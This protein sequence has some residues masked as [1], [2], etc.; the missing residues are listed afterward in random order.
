MTIATIML[1]MALLMILLDVLAGFHNAY[2]G[3]VT[4][5]ALPGC[6]FFGLFVAVIGIVRTRRR[7]LKEGVPDKLPVIDL[8]IPKQRVTATAVALGGLVLMALSGFGSYKGYEYTE[9]VQFC[10]T[11]CHAVMEPE[12]TTYQGSPHARVAC[13]GCHIGDGVDW[14]VKSKLSGSYQ[15]YATLLNKYERPIKTPVANLRPAKETCEQCHWPKHFFTQKLRTHEYFL[16]DEENTQHNLGMLVK[17][18]GGEGAEAQGIHA[19]MYLDT[20]V[21]YI[22]TDYERQEIPYVEMK[23]KDGK[24]I[25]YRDPSVK[26][27]DAD[28]AKSKRFVVDCIDCHNRPTHVFRAPSKTIDSA[29]ALG[30][31]DKTIPEI[32]SEAV[33]M[34]DASYKTKD[35]AIAKIGTDL[36]SYYNENYADFMKKDRPKLDS[37]ISVIQGIYRQNYFPEMKTDWRSHRDNLD[38]MRGKGCFRCHNNKLVSSTGKKITNDCKT[39]H[40]IVSQ[41][42]PGKEKTNYQG[43][44]FQHPV[45]I[46]N[47]WK[48]TPCMECHGA[49]K[50]E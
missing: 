8:N 43:M 29:L 14:Y 18:G 9:S 33:E 1:V 28:I 21:S 7:H 30:K 36:V 34:L 4:Y 37:A 20:E 26:L 12:Y 40:L 11:T 49:K 35:E 2:A 6:M 23:D 32:K 48:T 13:V 38:H 42:A 16:S 22:A 50:D 10:G 44:E 25:V 3:L 46:E 45:D 47:E 5:I 17:I 41:G 24:V 39:C 27:S 15:L 19:H 31:I